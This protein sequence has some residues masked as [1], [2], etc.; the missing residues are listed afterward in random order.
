MHASRGPR[1]R[2]IEE[3]GGI[4]S[5]VFAINH[6]IAVDRFHPRG[7]DYIARFICGETIIVIYSF[8]IAGDR[9]FG[10]ENITYGIVFDDVYSER[11]LFPVVFSMVS[12]SIAID[13]S[14]KRIV[15]TGFT[16]SV[17]NSQVVAAFRDVFPVFIEDLAV[18][19]NRSIVFKTRGD[20]KFVI[21]R[22]FILE[23]IIGIFPNNRIGMRSD[24]NRNIPL[25]DFN[26]ARLSLYVVIRRA[27]R[28]VW[29]ID[30]ID[31]RGIGNLARF[32]QVL[33][34]RIGLYIDS[35]GTL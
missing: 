35:I 3:H 34:Q 11:M 33:R 20:I 6:A 18:E 1:G 15:I 12:G 23:R 5:G 7:A 24:I 28:R 26:G 14:L 19:G 2:A 4:A 16:G 8:S 9:N 29:A 17:V 30:M 31:L 13:R 22:E 32:N 21:G 25:Q 10:V 27:I